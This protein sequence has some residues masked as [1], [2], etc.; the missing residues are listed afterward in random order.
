MTY[1]NLPKWLRKWVDKLVSAHT[2]ENPF[3]GELGDMSISLKDAKRFLQSRGGSFDFGS[4]DFG[5]G[6]GTFNLLGALVN[7]LKSISGEGMTNADR[8]RMDYQ[9]E[10]NNRLAE[11]DLQRKEQFYEKYES[12]GAQVRQMQ[13]A[14]LNPALMY[15]GGAGASA[16]GGTNAGSVSGSSAGITDVL[17]SVL[18]MAFKTQQLKQDRELRSRELD[19][20]E[21]KNVAYGDYLRSLTRGQ[22]ISNEFRAAQESAKLENVRANT[23]VL[24]DSLKTAEVQ[25]R[26]AESGITQNEADAALKFREALLM[27]IE[28]KHRDEYLKL[29]NEYQ[30]LVNELQR[31]TN[32]LIQRHLAAQIRELNKRADLLQEQA[33]MVVLERDGQAITNG[34]LAKEYNTWDKTYKRN[35]A[36]SWVRSGAQVVGAVA[37][38]VTGGAALGRLLQPSAQVVNNIPNTILPPPSGLTI[39]STGPNAGHLGR[40][41]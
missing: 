19:I 14:G 34:L 36:Q 7:Y 29:Q 17:G 33:A 38:V 25:R 30:E 23:A 31:A 1:N 27:E 13:D 6:A 4:F 20:E 9:G 15:Q 40:V 12:Y 26:L 21:Q 35:V 5:S 18:Q 3:A 11:A 32:P 28:A 2:S 24:Q 41:F 39:P 16:T 22:D 37:G 10:W 8:E